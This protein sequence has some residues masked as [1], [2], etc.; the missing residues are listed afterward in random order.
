MSPSRPRPRTAV[1]GV[2]LLLALTGTAVAVTTSLGSSPARADVMLP[3]FDDCQALTDRLPELF[4]SAYSA[5]F[6]RDYH[7]RMGVRSL[8]DE[9]LGERLVPALWILFGAVALVLV[10][11]CANVAGL[12]LVRAE[13]RRRSGKSV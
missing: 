4:P 5:G 9:V 8:R 10:I 3:A 11:A 2:A 12:F 13:A 1:G 7:F 6:L